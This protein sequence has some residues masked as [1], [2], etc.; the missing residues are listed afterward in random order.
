MGWYIRCIERY[1]PLKVNLFGGGVCKSNSGKVKIPKPLVIIDAGNRL[2]N[3][4]ILS[5][6]Y[7]FYD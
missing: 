7:N 2:R 4:L 3:I 5:I 1:I 6:L